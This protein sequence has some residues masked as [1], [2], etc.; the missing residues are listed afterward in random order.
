M[1]GTD[2]GELPI[3][4]SFVIVLAFVAPFEAV[5]ES[6]LR[7]LFEVDRLVLNQVA[8]VHL[9]NYILIHHQYPYYHS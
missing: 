5:S 1:E 7:F 3:A 6:E 4:D 2:A 9:L 8:L